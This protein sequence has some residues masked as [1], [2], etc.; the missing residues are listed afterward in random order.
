MKVLISATGDTDPIRD[1]HDG[2]LLHIARKYRPDQIVIIYSER[3]FEKKE[4][5]ELAIRS[6]PKYHPEIITHSETIPDE[7]VYHFDLM[8]DKV[9][10]IIQTYLDKDN[11]LILNLSSATPQIKAA[12]F[13]ANRLNDMNVTAVQVLSPAHGSNE[14]V[15]HANKE[16]IHDLIEYNFD[17]EVNYEDRT[18]EDKSEKF[19]LA[20]LK[21]NL[22]NLISHYDYKAAL[23]ML[24][25]V[26][27]FP[28]SKLLRDKLK[29]IVKSHNKQGLPRG[30]QKKKLSDEEKKILNSFL[31]IDLQKKRGNL[32]ES[33]IRIKSLTEYL[34]DYLITKEFP[35]AVDDYEDVYDKAYLN[36]LDYASILKKKKCGQFGR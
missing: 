28:H 36:L 24:E 30:I 4:K 16:D 7:V 27:E 11:E 9:S 5:I 35:D 17:N 20:L 19:S 13:I 23:D 3:T 32:S 14:E 22:R 26:A 29:D 25:Q 1:F 8:Y 18:V 15:S 31:L 2:A 34:L 12:F 6:I 10:S 21:R 33:L